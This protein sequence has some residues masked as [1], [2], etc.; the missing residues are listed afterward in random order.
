MYADDGSW[1]GLTY[2]DALLQLVA[3]DIGVLVITLSPVLSLDEDNYD[4]LRRNIT[5][6]T[7]ELVFA[8]DGE[9]FEDALKIA[10]GDGTEIIVESDLPRGVKVTLS[11]S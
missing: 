3:M 10:A 5:D 6:T 8:V 4:V 1:R 7:P 11:K 2:G 9:P